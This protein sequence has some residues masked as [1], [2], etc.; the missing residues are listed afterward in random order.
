MKNRRLL[1]AILQW[2]PVL[3]P[4]FAP[5]SG[6]DASSQGRRHGWH[7][8]SGGSGD[9]PKRTIRAGRRRPGDSSEPGERETAQ[10]PRRERPSTDEGPK[11]AGYSTGGGGSYQQPSSSS[12][13]QLPQ[14]SL[15]KL[16]PKM[17]IIIVGLLVVVGCC[18]LIYVL[19]SGG[20][21][22]LN[23][24]YVETP[25]ETVELGQLFATD[26]PE[27][28]QPTPIVIRATK[29]PK[30]TK[31]TNTVAPAKPTRTPAPT[32][33]VVQPPASS[34]DQ[35]WLVM[36]YQD[37]DDKI[38]EQDIYIDLNEAERAGST[39]RV[40]I[41]AQMDRYKGGFSDDGNWTST[42][43][44][45]ITQDNDLTRVRSQQ[46]ADLGEVNM[47]DGDT[48][49]DFVTWAVKSYPADKY[50]L[51]LSDHGMGW[52]GGWSDADPG[53][54]GAQ[55][56]RNIPLSSATGDEIFLMELDKAL[57]DIRAQVGLDKFEIVGMDAC[58]M[59]H[60]EVLSALEPHARYAVVSQETEPSVGWAYTAFLQAL[61]DNP[62][63]TG[64]DLAK[65]I[66]KTY[67]QDDQRIVDDQARAEMV[68]RG[69]SG[70]GLLGDYSQVSAAQLVQQISQNST[71][72]AVDLAK[73]PDLTAST[74][75]LAYAMTKL[76]QKGVAQ[77]RSY[78]QSFTS[79]FGSNVPP[80]YLDLGNLAALLRDNSTNAD[81]DQAANRVLAALGQAVIAEKHGQGKPGSTG[82][83]I[84]FPNSQLYQNAMTGP[85][86][87]TPVAQRFAQESLWDDFL[88]YHYTGRTFQPST[89]EIVVPDVSV[90]V[91]GPGAGGIQVSS[92]TASSD[93]ASPS[94]PVLLSTDISGENVGYV[95]LFAGFLDQE[96][97]S[98][99]VA[100][101]DY[102]DSGDTQEIDGV[103]YP[104]WGEGAFTMEFEW[105][106]LMFAV[107]DGTTSV[108][109]AL[110][111]QSF[112]ASS[113]QAVYAVDGI[114]T[115]A[116]G[117][118]SR[119]ARLYFSNGLLRQVF[120]FTGTDFTGAPHEINPN[121]GDTFTILDKW[122]DLDASGGAATM[123]SQ[124]G[125]TLTFGNQPFTW[126]EMNA[127]PGQYQVGFIVKDLDGNSYETYTTITVT[128]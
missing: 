75:E 28:V 92:I 41:V 127:A 2:V 27:P 65:L 63:M 33:A 48:L 5:V 93:T 1:D 78:V 118:E 15:G 87:Y 40:Q 46:L 4:A 71:L 109:A 112:G 38:L 108:T 14:I 70:G 89:R 58:L 57:G 122:M 61:D 31:P 84:Y 59:G 100:D 45:Y 32:Q 126:K 64:A 67:I 83:S 105:E 115:D 60:L 6:T 52:P 22:G 54:G 37:A 11:G 104:N 95:Y 102:L 101:M 88:A 125:G 66:V 56:D 26:T 42:K 111:P 17:L 80:S 23:T 36:L 85:R 124:E 62:D 18:C 97:N 121:T 44:F 49:V 55:A 29:T 96:A 16:S 43:R 9:E 91:R 35:K 13:G 50:V 7:A 34:G 73:L 103:Y 53:A 68:G 77:A 99:Y 3:A 90:P 119:Y 116:N 94:Q 47:S 82:V 24:G 98:I 106:P 117:G 25:Q 12:G 19:V 39:D 8:M 86:S 69:Y 128:Q 110:M 79:V 114:Y 120:G 107:N 21:Q 113:E 81:V 51:V 123:A 10:A 72:T 76:N 74:N 30:V 20:L